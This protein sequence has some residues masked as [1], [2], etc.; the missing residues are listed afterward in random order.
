MKTHPFEKYRWNRYGFE[1][2]QEVEWF[3]WLHKY[4]HALRGYREQLKKE[5]FDC[6]EIMER[7]IQIKD[8]ILQ[9]SQTISEFATGN[10]CRQFHGKFLKSKKVDAVDL[11][12]FKSILL[13]NYEESESKDAKYYLSIIKA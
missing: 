10:S 5:R 7:Y 4:K 12:K 1:I 2:G 8:E 9:I 3:E 13:K 6:S 11:V